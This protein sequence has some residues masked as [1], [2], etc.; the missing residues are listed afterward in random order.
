MKKLILKL[1]RLS[2]RITKIQT[3]NQIRF[4]DLENSEVSKQSVSKEK[5]ET[6]RYRFTTRSW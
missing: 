6:S 5:K 3:D 4:S 2:N 1:I